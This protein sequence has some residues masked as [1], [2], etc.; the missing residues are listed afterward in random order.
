MGRKMWQSVDARDGVGPLRRGPY[1]NRKDKRVR[2]KN[3][4]GRTMYV[5][6]NW[7]IYRNL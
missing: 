4:G 7:K 6:E 2:L 3:G 5:P 1:K